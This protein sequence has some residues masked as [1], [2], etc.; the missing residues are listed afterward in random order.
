MASYLI[1]CRL[2][3]VEAEQFDAHHSFMVRTAQASGTAHKRTG[4]HSPV[5]IC[6]V[7]VPSGV[8]TVVFPHGVSAWCRALLLARPIDPKAPKAA[9]V[10]P[11]HTTFRHGMSVLCMCALLIVRAC[12]SEFAQ[13]SVCACVRLRTTCERMLCA[14]CAID[15]SL[16]FAETSGAVSE[17]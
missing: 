16:R 12:V 17:R 11:R 13:V 1:G 3:A 4:S 6:A 7:R 8:R 2:Y 9:T 10:A 5:R 15:D 14:P